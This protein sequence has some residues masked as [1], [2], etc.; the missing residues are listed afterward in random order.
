MS[1]EGERAM[2]VIPPK[3]G[4]P[5][6]YDQDVADEICGMIASGLSL[7]AA[8]KAPGMPGM[9]TV[10][11][12]R[13][14]HPSFAEAYTR[15]REDQA[16]AFADE[17]MAISDDRSNDWVQDPDTG[18]WKPDHDHINR[19]KLRVE[20]RKWIA[21]RL[22]PSTYGDRVEAKLS[23]EVVNKNIN[24][25]VAIDAHALSPAQRDALRAALLP[26]LAKPR[27]EADDEGEG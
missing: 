1:D 5:E 21:S 27:N 16:D 4:R 18:V 8:L 14:T 22:K 26:A 25:N 12:W 23:G 13:R 24:V 17:M 19:A 10:M 3:R 20:T 7:V 6:I 2:M 9:T 11:K 15:A